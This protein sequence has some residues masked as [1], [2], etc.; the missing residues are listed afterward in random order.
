MK[1]TLRGSLVL[2]ATLCLALVPG[3][4]KEPES[5]SEHEV[6]DEALAGLARS[7]FNAEFDNS[8]AVLSTIIEQTENRG[9]AYRA[10]LERSRALLDLFLAALTSRDAKLFEHLHALLK[11]QLD[12]D[13]LSARSFQQVA[14]ALLESFRVL[15][16]EAGAFPEVHDKAE[17]LA[18]LSLGLQGV[19]FREKQ[20]YFK[21]RDAVAR[22][23]SL[24]YLD[25]FLAVRDLIHE[26]LERTD[27]PQKN[28]QNVVLTVVGRT[29]PNPAA[30]YVSTLCRASNPVDAE[31]FCFTDF[32]EIP[33]DRRNNGSPIL[34]SKCTMEISAGTKAA[35]LAAVTAWYDR[36]FD[37][38]NNDEQL[39]PGLRNVLAPMASRRLKAYEALK[40]FF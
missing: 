1:R 22:H 8:L 2:A 7:G 26:T 6:V 21:G 34:A 38:L 31:Q 3:C 20:A 14:Q 23:A 37:Q 32:N 16:R 12:G 30:A 4:R 28:W 27:G 10:I 33:E 39:R 19:L 29:C 11:M 17:A 9:L 15:E 24:R 35:G 36:A 18:S 25:D 13:P 40:L 5:K